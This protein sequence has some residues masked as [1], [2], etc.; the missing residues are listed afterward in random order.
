MAASLPLS[1]NLLSEI[2]GGFL[3]G[4]AIFAHQP[5]A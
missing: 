4:V 3:Q 1:A 5:R 2:G